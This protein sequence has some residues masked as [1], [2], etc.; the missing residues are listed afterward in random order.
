MDE[1]TEREAIVFNAGLPR[2]AAENLAHQWQGAI[3]AVDM[4]YAALIQAHAAT[5]EALRARQQKALS[6]ADA[7]ERLGLTEQ[8]IG[9]LLRAGKLRGVKANS[10]WIVPLDA[11][12][13]FVARTEET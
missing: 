6:P 5:H 8:M 13:E 4:Q 11:L 9:R 3:D 1:P 12:D 2:N 10:V 7:A